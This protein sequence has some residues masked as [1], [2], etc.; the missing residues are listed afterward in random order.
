MASTAESNHMLRMFLPGK[1]SDMKVKC[2]GI[3]F[4]VLRNILCSQSH[5]FEAAMSGGFKES[6]SCVVDL[7]D[8]DPECIERVLAFLYI[9]DYSEAGH[10][11]TFKAEAASDTKGSSKRKKAS[12][13]K[14]SRKRKTPH[15]A[16]DSLTGASSTAADEIS[17]IL[18]V[19]LPVNN[20]S[21]S[22]EPQSNPPEKVP[23]V[24]GVIF[25]NID[26]YIAADKFGIDMLYALA[27]SRICTWLSANT[28]S[29]SFL[30][31]AQKVMS[32]T[33]PH[34]PTLTDHL[35]QLMTG[36]LSIFAK[37][38]EFFPLLNEFGALGSN[39]IAR[40]HTINT[41]L[42]TGLENAEKKVAAEDIMIKDRD[43]QIHKLQQTVQCK[44]CRTGFNGYICFNTN[45]DNVVL[46]CRSCH[47][48]N[49]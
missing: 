41:A 17:S 22:V 23:L 34:D 3:S 12:S 19:D 46:K 37:N 24:D 16:K 40:M 48:I 8:D 42:T 39:I 47:A 21:T 6:S 36:K 33:P 1:Y 28:T 20:P 38:Q 45:P 32:S 13:I 35:A 30:D 9:Q 27:A 18:P 14:A 44:N 5:F 31:A 4:D 49:Q 7:P 29:E 11:Q 10:T 26:V 15:S 2:G 25:N 43:A